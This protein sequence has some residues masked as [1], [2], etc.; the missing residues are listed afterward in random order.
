MESNLSGKVLNLILLL[1]PK[2]MTWYKI[3]WYSVW[4]STKGTCQRGSCLQIWC[5]GSSTTICP[6][7]ISFDAKFVYPKHE[8][9]EQIRIT[10]EPLDNI[11][12]LWCIFRTK[13]VWWYLPYH[14]SSP[15]YFGFLQQFSHSSCDC[16][17]ALKA[18]IYSCCFSW[19]LLCDAVTFV[20]WYCNRWS[21]SQHIGPYRCMGD[22]KYK[23]SNLHIP[24]KET[25][26]RRMWSFLDYVRITAKWLHMICW[27]KF[28]LFSGKP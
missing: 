26:I 23:D 9:T 12:C 20:V 25:Q 14:G 28:W 27:N 16:K 13:R 10:N 22:N 8:Q 1:C 4:L 7:N 11:A 6:L 3:Q 15:R 5:R 2:N 24:V 18:L 17:T 21:P 19:S